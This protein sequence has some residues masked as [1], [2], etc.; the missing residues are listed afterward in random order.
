[1]PLLDQRKGLAG[2]VVDAATEELAE[3]ETTPSG[4]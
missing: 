3:V 4:R 1:M 2:R